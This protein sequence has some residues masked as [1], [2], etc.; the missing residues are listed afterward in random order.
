MVRLISGGA[1]QISNECKRLQMQ[2]FIKTCTSPNIKKDLDNALEMT[3]F[4]M[5]PPYLSDICKTSRQ[6]ERFDENKDNL[7]M[8]K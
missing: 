1:Q 2:A 5:F 8:Y 7:N 4:V 6:L 3:D